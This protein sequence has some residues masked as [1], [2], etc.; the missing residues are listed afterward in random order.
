LLKEVACCACRLSFD[1]VSLLYLLQQEEHL[2]YFSCCSNS[3][4]IIRIPIPGLSN[5]REI[6]LVKCQLLVVA[7][8]ES[9]AALCE[10]SLCLFS[11]GQV[12]CCVCRQVSMLSNMIDNMFVPEVSAAATPTGDSNGD[13]TVAHNCT[14]CEE[15][16][17][18]GYF[19]TDCS[20]WLCEPCAQ[21]HR[22]VKVTKDHN[23][24][25]I[26][27]LSA[28][29]AGSS[30]NLLATTGMPKRR[31]L[32]CPAHPNELLKLYCETCVKLTCRDCQ[33]AE[34]RDHKYQFVQVIFFTIPVCL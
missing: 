7:A 21:A 1:S 6:G 5:L 14:G 9:V 10:R 13:S 31:S 33:L 19:C 17:A 32:M 4:N 20:E 3:P 18:A 26:G 16:V 15:N 22:R 24:E 12:T 34:H 28:S 29:A 30:N 27:Q 23:V 11:D 25:S 8:A 2:A